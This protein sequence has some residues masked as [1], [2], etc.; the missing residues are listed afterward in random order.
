MNEVLTD[1]STPALITALRWNFYE[2]CWELRDHW[3]QAVFEETEKQRRWWTPM[4]IAFIFNAA[5][6]LQPPT[7]DE[8]DHI[9]ETI[10]F[11]QSRGRTS[12]SWWLAPGLEESD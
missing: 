3:K 4:P 2:A 12:F 8:A 11:F 7:G 10:E 6:S 5:L 1:L 9:H